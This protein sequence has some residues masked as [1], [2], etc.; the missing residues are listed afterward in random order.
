MVSRQMSHEALMLQ[1]Q[2]NK[3]RIHRAFEKREVVFRR[4]PSFARPGKRLMAEPTSSGPFI[5]EDQRSLSSLVLRDPRTNELVD[6]GV[7]I[8]LDQILAGP[9]RSLVRFEDRQ[10]DV[11]GIGEMLRGEGRPP[12]GSQ[13]TPHRGSGPG[14]RKGWAGLGAGACV[15]YQVA[16]QGPAAKELVVGKYYG[17]SQRS[18]R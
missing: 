13:A 18:R 6:A 9:Y 16:G 15:A 8:P 10:S 12:D 7:N 4:M 2:I 3:K 5:V 14:R 1:K 11:R 17:T